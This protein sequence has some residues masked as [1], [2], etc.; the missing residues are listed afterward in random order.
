MK[1]DFA[2]Q[3]A[4]AECRSCGV[5]VSLSVASR[6]NR[7]Y[8]CRSCRTEQNKEYRQNPK[9]KARQREY[10]KQYAIDNYDRLL[11][12]SREWRENNREIH[13]AAN[14]RWRIENPE[15]AKAQRK[16][17]HEVEMGRMVRGACEACGSQKTQGHHEDYS[18]P[19]EVVWLCAKHHGQRHRTWERLVLPT[20]AKEESDG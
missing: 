15:K 12:K 10:S 17:R 20:E 2:R 19:L 7:I 6:R 13:N 14:R 16:L 11:D 18:K 4:E 8:I 9:A 5:G 1:T 3:A